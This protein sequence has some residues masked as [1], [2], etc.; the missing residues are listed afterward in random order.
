MHIVP[1]GKG[2]HLAHGDANDLP[3]RCLD[4]VGADVVDDGHGTHANQP[5]ELA[6]ADYVVFIVFSGVH[7]NCVDSGA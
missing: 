2:F 6:D 7:S 3:R 4:A 1:L 5:R